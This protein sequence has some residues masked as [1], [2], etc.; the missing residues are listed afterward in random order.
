MERIIQRL[1]NLSE[2]YSPY[3]YQVYTWF[4]RRGKEVFSD[5][6]RETFAITL[7][8]GRKQSKLLA[9][10]NPD[11]VKTHGLIEAWEEHLQIPEHKRTVMVKRGLYLYMRPSRYWRKTLYHASFFASV[12]KQGFTFDGDLKEWFLNHDEYVMN[13]ARPTFQ[14]AYLNKRVKVKGVNIKFHFR[15]IA[16]AC[17][18][19]PTFT[20]EVRA[21]WN[22]LFSSKA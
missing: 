18:N 22:S 8:T 21:E 9:L 11:V 6:C 3:S 4:T 7:K 1:N 13:H 10:H 16:N 17:I 5:N 12:L 19:T 14:Y 15:F 2:P 20:R